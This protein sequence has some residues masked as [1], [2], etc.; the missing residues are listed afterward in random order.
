MRVYGYHTTKVLR[1]W[2]TL[3]PWRS[4]TFYS[5]LLWD[6]DLWK[7]TDR[8]NLCHRLRHERQNC[9]VCTK[10]ALKSKQVFIKCISICTDG[11]SWDFNSCVGLFFLT[12]GLRQIS[13]GVCRCGWSSKV[14]HARNSASKNA[15][16]LRTICQLKGYASQSLWTNP[17]K[18]NLFG[19]SV[20]KPHNKHEEHISHVI[21]GWAPLIAR[22]LDPT[23]LQRWAKSKSY[24][25]CA[26]IEV[27]LP[28][29]P[30]V[31]KRQCC[32]KAR[33]LDSSPATVIIS[34]AGAHLLN[35]SGSG[36]TNKIRPIPNASPSEVS[37]LGVILKTHTVNARV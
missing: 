14:F 21:Q 2:P 11:L 30:I 31:P 15:C 6:K 19:G 1:A 16:L 9:L 3:H 34:K 10:S 5:R 28:K 18:P 23:R 13:P 37:A 36:K 22:S 17:W 24:L 4:K 32:Y 33:E 26:C 20:S 29:A 35:K 25:P 27:P 7:S 12:R 8:R